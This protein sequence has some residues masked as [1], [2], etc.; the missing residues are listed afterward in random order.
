MP[1]PR[2]KIWF[3]E[4]RP[5]GP[6]AAESQ[7]LHNQI[8]D[9][10]AQGKTKAEIASMLD[11]DRDTVRKVTWKARKNGDARGFAK[12][13]PIMI[14]TSFK[15]HSVLDIYKEQYIVRGLARALE[16]PH[17]Q[18]EAILRVIAKELEETGK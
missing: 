9:L 7:E 16:V 15:T 5:N 4:F 6:R 14:R 3:H 2:S 11:I 10:W 1:T 17:A 18:I 13:Q 12:T 8:L